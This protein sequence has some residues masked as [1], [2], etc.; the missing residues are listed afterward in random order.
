MQVKLGV[1]MID[2]P[3]QSNKLVSAYLNAFRIVWILI[4]AL[5]LWSTLI[6]LSSIFGVNSLICEQEPCSLANELLASEL[7]ALPG[8]GN[9]VVAYFAVGDFV[10]WLVWI[11]VGLLL[12]IRKSGELL[13]LVASLFLATFTTAILLG[14][15]YSTAGPLTMYALYIF[16]PVG[17]F[18][19][20]LLLYLFPNGQ[21]VPRWARWPAMLVLL[22][23]PFEVLL[24][25]FAP[26]FF[27]HPVYGPLDIG[28]YFALFAL[29]VIL[30]FY[31][32]RSASSPIQRQQTK[33]VLTAIAMLPLSDLLFRGLV[34]PAIFP[35]ATTPGT[36]HVIY[37]MIT[38]LLFR[39]IPFLMIPI[40]FGLAIL[41]HRLW[42]IDILIRRTLVY[43]ILTAILAFLYYSGVV[44]IQQVLHIVTG[45]AEQS[46]LAIV[47]STL[48][49]AAVFI[50]LRRRIQAGID[51]RFYRNKY[52]AERTLEG[53]AETLRD[54]VDI[55]RLSE[56]LVS[57][58]QETIQPEHLMLW[59]PKAG[60][61]AEN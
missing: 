2:S 55:D 41:R 18:S 61:K 13:G 11:G 26:E 43:A 44:L 52:D 33:W 23:I 8:Q 35:L 58:V 49:I 16:T 60:Q 48:A 12:F 9:F 47:L 27:D 3:V 59:M 4:V 22:M 1:E 28:I 34:L 38:I 21:F 53:F 20:I 42:D 10:T 19:P 45:R 32:Y 29:G 40:S 50:P 17:Q 46:P 36:A 30:Q 54:E 51:R 7:A 56:H 14:N 39:T 5:G 37:Y 25:I 6:H 57:V 15:A 31:R 24:Y